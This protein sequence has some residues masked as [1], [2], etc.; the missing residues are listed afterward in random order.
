MHWDND[1]FCC[2]TPSL[3]KKSPCFNAFCRLVLHA[4]SWHRCFV[5]ASAP[6]PYASWMWAKP[7][8]FWLGLCKFNL[9]EWPRWTTSTA[10]TQSATRNLSACL[11]HRTTPTLLL[12]SKTP[13]KVPLWRLQPFASMWSIA[14]GRWSLCASLSASCSTSVP[15]WR[16]WSSSF[17]T[18]MQKM[19]SDGKW[20]AKPGIILAQRTG[21][22]GNQMF[23][24]MGHF[25][26]KN[27]Y[28]SF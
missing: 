24:C 9:L 4:W 23:D 7:Q 13:K 25:E 20:F 14:R 17:G 22:Q 26:K 8:A 3:Q 10:A 11:L 6:C 27:I 16:K 5:W 21:L 15:R 2:H 19:Q 12:K 18:K 1:S 28:I